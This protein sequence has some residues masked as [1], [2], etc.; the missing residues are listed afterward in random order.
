MRYFFIILLLLA[1]FVS[2]G[3]SGKKTDGY[4]NVPRK[5]ITVVNDIDGCCAAYTDDGHTLLYSNDS[6][7]NYIVYYLKY[8]DNTEKYGQD[9]NKDHIVR[10]E[11]DSSLN[12]T[13]SIISVYGGAFCEKNS[14]T[15][16][17][18]YYFDENIKENSIDCID[19]PSCYEQLDV[20]GE[21]RIIK[22]I[23][24]LLNDA[25]IIAHSIDNKSA[26][27]WYNIVSALEPTQIILNYDVIVQDT[28]CDPVIYEHI[29]KIEKV[30]ERFTCY[31]FM[32]QEKMISQK[33]NN[34]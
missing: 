28:I 18:A 2:C 23:F 25:C 8:D 1:F 22:R 4:S 11:M 10:V 7:G 24:E 30:T 13:K 5:Y 9:W 33:V 20:T 31:Y 34:K 32:L 21:Y 15:G 3:S 17:N 12:M 19:V 14:D 6:V 27:G 26:S 16:Y 29:S